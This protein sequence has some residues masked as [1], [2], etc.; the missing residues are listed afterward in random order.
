VTSRCRRLLAPCSIGLILLSLGILT[1]AVYFRCA[2]LGWKLFWFDENWNSLL[3][4]GR[5]FGE[6]QE[7]LL[8]DRELGREE[9]LSVQRLHPQRGPWWTLR[10]MVN[11][12]AQHPPLYYFLLRLWAGLVGDSVVSFRAFSVLAGLLVIPLGYWLGQE[13]FGSRRAGWLAAA[14]IAVSPF[15]VLYSQQARPYSFWT[16]TILVSCIALVRA[17]R[18]GRRRDWVWYG[19]AVIVGLYTH[20]LFWLVLAAQGICVAA[21]TLDLKARPRRLPP[22]WARYLQVLLGAA[23]SFVPWALVIIR[24]RRIA[25]DNLNWMEAGGAPP[26]VV[27]AW[28]GGIASVF[29]DSAE[30]RTRLTREGVVAQPAVLPF[31]LAGLLVAYGLVFAVRRSAPPGRWLIT[32]LF[33]STMLPLLLADGLLGGMRSAVGRFQIPAYLAAQFAVAYL[34]ASKSESQGVFRRRAWQAVA[35]V[36]L[37]AGVVSSAANSRL[38]WT[39]DKRERTDQLLVAEVLNQSRPALVITHATME[40]FVRTLVLNRLVD[41]TVRFHYAPEPGRPRIQGEGREVFAF[42]ASR[43]L[44]RSLESEG[45]RFEPV[46]RLP[47]LWRLKR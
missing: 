4:S 14:L 35:A 43:P 30:L 12:Q 22:A 16:V 31:L 33:V 3:V 46:P 47:Y 39:W 15:H 34:L 20:L 45:W 9:L 41:A 44:R 5:W 18:L 7:S 11:D 27:K 40:N 36:V 2:N 26:V 32:G 17:L 10:A 25:H 28:L 42:H 19:V 13:L 21:G 1:F 38:L 8:N 37:L 23:L 29:V 6:L 24:G